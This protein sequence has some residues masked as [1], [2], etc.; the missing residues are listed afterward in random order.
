M[1]VEVF[2]LGEP[3]IYIDKEE[4]I[5]GKKKLEALL[6]F[7]LCHEKLDRSE[8]TSIFWPRHELSKGKSS[9][10]NSLYEIRRGLGVDLFKASTR[11]RIHISKDIILFKDVDRIVESSPD[12]ELTGYTSTI[13]MQSRELKNNPVYETWL[14]SM[15]TAYQSIMMGNLRTQLQRAIRSGE[16]YK[17]ITMAKDILKA[18]PYDEMTLRSLMKNYAKEGQYNDALASFFKM[19][20]ILKDDL[21]VEPEIETLKLADSIQDYKRQSEGKLNF[22]GRES[23]QLSALKE[24]FNGFENKSKSAHALV[25]GELGAGRTDLVCSFLESIRNKVYTLRLD[26]SNQKIP[27]GFLVKWSRQFK[28]QPIENFPRLNYDSADQPV[29]CVTEHLEY[30]DSESLVYLIDFLSFKQNDVFFLLKT[31]SAFLASCDPL[32]LLVYQG[33]VSEIELPLLSETELMEYLKAHEHTFKG[34][35]GSGEF[36]KVYDYSQGNVLLAQEYLEPKGRLDLLFTQ[37]TAGLSREERQLME[38]SS[39]YIEGFSPG[40]VEALAPQ[41]L[42][43]MNLLKELVHK[44]LV[45]ESDKL[46]YFKYPPLREWIYNRLPEFYRVNLHELAG[47]HAPFPS[48]SRREEARF[49]AWHFK[50]AYDDES[51]LSHQLLLLELTLNFYDQMY[52]SDMEPDDVPDHPD[53]MRLK[54][55][56]L[57]EEVA[58]EVELYFQSQPSTKAARMLL[59]T[60]YLKGR[61][62]IAGGRQDEGVLIIRQVV[63]QAEEVDDWEYLL[64]ATIELIHYGIQKDNRSIMEEN[65]QRAEKLIHHLKD[66]ENQHRRAEVLRLSGLNQFNQRNFEEALKQFNEADEILRKPR[67]VKTGFLARAGTLNYIGRTREAMGDIKGADKAFLASISLVEGR[68]HKCLDILYAEYGR[69]LWAQGRFEAADR[70]LGLALM[71][72]QILG[73][74]WKR[75]STEAILG[76]IRLQEGNLKV[77]RSHLVNAQIFH[78]AD[79]RKGEEVLIEKLVKE[80]SRYKVQQK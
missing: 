64:K 3:R 57:L 59:V 21:S 35:L 38:I 51:Y 45:I 73:T 28:G 13:F 77:A 70:I 1:Q 66:D 79:R 7:L 5:L 60:D 12:E 37:L 68:L 8:V 53:Q 10:R 20:T 14:L 6:F 47:K 43:W 74:H 56:A 44:G 19:K 55:Y 65:I 63:K 17:V 25:H 9:L 62:M 58:K 40:L 75:P 23:P 41:P 76:L 72:Y 32:R 67:Y 27:K 54:Q 69:F 78:K 24:L 42:D 48:A 16:S 46:L 31:T 33:E 71:E 80:M 18:E 39:I 2:F 22:K 15:R 11:E 50:K 34:S 26:F 4:K 61:R 36:K 52:P 30:I 29:V 49:R